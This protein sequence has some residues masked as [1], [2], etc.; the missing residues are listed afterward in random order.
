MDRHK[1]IAGI[2]LGLLGFACNWFKLELFLNVDF[3]F[4]SFITL[5]ALLR[6]GLGSALLATLIASSCTVLLWNHPWAVLILL[7][8]LLFVGWRCRK[9]EE[10]NLLV[11]DMIFWLCCGAP[12]VWLFY[13]LVMGVSLQQ[14]VLIMLKQG[15][16]GVVNALFA[17]L[18]YLLFQLKQSD[19]KNL[20]SFRQLAFVVMV[21]LVTLPA[22]IFI[23]L[24]LRGRLSAGQ[25]GLIRQTTHVAETSQIALAAWIDDHHQHVK[26]LAQSIG[27]PARTTQPEM[28]RLTEVL[29]KSSLQFK[30][31]GV[32]DQRAIT[33]AFYP[34]IDEFG[35]PTLGTDFSSRAFIPILKETKRP[36]VPD[37][38]IARFGKPV[39]ML[40]L[41][42]PIIVK[43]EYRGYC[44]G[45]LDLSSLAQNLTQQVGATGVELT[46]ID[47]NRRIIASSRRKLTV[48]ERY[49]LPTDGSFHQIGSGVSFWV[50]QSQKGISIMQRWRK[51]LYI[52][53]LQVS[54]EVNWTVVAEAPLLP[55]LERLTRD[56]ISSLFILAWL[57]TL[58]V[59][60]AYLISA[61]IGR[62]LIRLQEVSSSLPQRLMVG[63][64]P[65]L[66][67]FPL[68]EF[69]GLGSN[70][71]QMA[72]A[73][74]YSF[75]SLKTINET[76][77]EKVEERTRQ[78]EQARA[79]ADAANQ[80]K[81]EF[82]ANM[83]HEIRTP[84]N[85]VIGMS[86]LM[87]FTELSD[88]QQDYLNN[89]EISADSLL[90]LINDILD[91]SKIEAGKVELDYADFSLRKIINDIINTQ[92]SHIHKKQLQVQTDLAPTVPDNLLGDQ[93][94]IKQILL[95]LLSNAIKFTSQGSITMG[96]EVLS[97]SADQVVLRLSVKD[98]GIG[99]SSQAMDKIFASFTQADSSTTRKYGGT[100][101]GLSISRHLAE[102]MGG[103]LWA[104]STA[105]VG[106]S[107]HLELPFV[108]RQQAAPSIS[109]SNKNELV[110][111]GPPLKVLVAE[112]NP[113]NASF[114]ISLLAKMGHQV[115]AVE[116]GSQALERLQLWRF[117]CILMDEQM[118][119]MSGSEAVKTIRVMEKDSSRHTQIIALTAN[120]LRGDRE[121]FLSAGF[122][123][124]LPKPVSVA[125]LLEEL[126][127]VVA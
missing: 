40:P 88:E 113:I 30:R 126:R 51:S 123:G 82:L 95:N 98:T 120:A 49:E 117:D 62:A 96:V 71:R 11:A 124:Y 35:K 92:I 102:L 36:Y 127:R 122:D 46:I 94:R 59:G 47:R 101:L 27:D 23:S 16:N 74:K 33:I 64:E 45:I 76:L 80:A 10:K 44:A 83:S 91:L 54:T 99:I 84:M 110:W 89:I 61:F 7:A 25:E 111:D 63:Q 103:N 78:L 20:P 97:G 21:T 31:G 43:G 50:P 37:L 125:A 12:L 1:L 56:T 34:L 87:R 67:H 70:F 13:H 109:E 107:F 65:E 26:T 112:D 29:L 52:K 114:L 108:V 22:L 58:T 8:E 17:C 79:A 19:S 68:R 38:V 55:L 119:V 104:E 100:G 3:L 116:N 73:L 53:E 28:Q 69:E 90:S 115:E 121:K 42:A 5:F 81:S 85:G 60:L 105:G 86:Q 106:S 6:F 72:Q 39:P 57:M 24:Q 48:M 75:A 41:L 15:I 118:P 77:E 2:L 4:G 14:T 93:L 18:A 32:L 66:P 9:N